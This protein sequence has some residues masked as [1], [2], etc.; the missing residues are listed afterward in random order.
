MTID[1]AGAADSGPMALRCLLSRVAATHGPS[2]LPFGVSAD[3]GFPFR[4]LLSRPPA[5][6]F[7]FSSA[8]VSL[9]SPRAMRSPGGG[10]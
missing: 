3:M 1:G 6:F 10:F 8:K 7:L 9:V 5:G 2:A 4:L